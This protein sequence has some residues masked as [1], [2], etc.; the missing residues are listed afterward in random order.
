MSQNSELS[1]NNIK[2]I[3]GL[4]PIQIIDTPLFED[5]KGIKKGMLITSNIEK[6]LKEAAICFL[7]QLSKARLAINQ[8]YI[9]GFIWWGC[10]RIFYSNANFLC[11]WNSSS[12]IIH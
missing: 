2:W 6:T 4:P 1:A 9:F 3:N 7:V 11:W 8:K 10:K 5:T 12:N